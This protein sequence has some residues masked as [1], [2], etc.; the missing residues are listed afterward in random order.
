MAQAAGG[1]VSGP[2]ASGPRPSGDSDR[3]AA[4]GVACGPG[5]VQ[6]DADGASG[7]AGPLEG[8]ARAAQAPGVPAARPRAQ[9]PPPAAPPQA[10]SAAGA[11][12]LQRGRHRHQDLREAV[13]AAAH[14]PSA[15]C[16]PT[17]PARSRASAPACRRQRR[18]WRPRPWLRPRRRSRRRPTPSMRSGR[19]TLVRGGETRGQP[20]WVAQRVHARARA[21]RWAGSTGHVWQHLPERVTRHQSRLQGA[22]NLHAAST[23]AAVLAQCA[24]TAVSLWPPSGCLASGPAL[25]WQPQGTL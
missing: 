22:L 7:G 2:Q 4:R 21:G 11:S 15:C 12:A 25:A 1:A 16:V 6:E 18:R 8:A 17:P 3:R 20:C 10:C 24:E 14:D 5:S 13:K 9:R 19:R 23:A